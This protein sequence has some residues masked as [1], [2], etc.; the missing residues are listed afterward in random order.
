MIVGKC[1]ASLAAEEKSERKGVRPGETEKERNV[2][3]V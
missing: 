3:K 1:F 2:A